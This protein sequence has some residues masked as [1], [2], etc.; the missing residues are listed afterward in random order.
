MGLARRGLQGGVTSPASIV[1]AAAAD[2]TANVRPASTAV[3]AVTLAAVL[4]V[5]FEVV[6]VL[7]ATSLF[8]DSW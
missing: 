8:S 1:V 7:E 5:P 2:S 3:L 6:P 4:D